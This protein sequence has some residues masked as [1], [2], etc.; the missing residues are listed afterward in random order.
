MVERIRPALARFDQAEV[1]LCLAL[2]NVRRRPLPG[3]L[4]KLVGRMSDGMCWYVLLAC[5][6]VFYGWA[7]V[8]ASLHAG[9]MALVGVAVTRR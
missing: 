2:N 4:F 5:L 7:G 3:R 8:R 6:P 9:I 1:K